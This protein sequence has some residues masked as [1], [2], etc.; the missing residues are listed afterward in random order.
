MLFKTAPLS[1]SFPSLGQTP[2]QK[3]ILLDECMP[4]VGFLLLDGADPDQRSAARSGADVFLFLID[5]IQETFGLAPI[6]GMAAGLPLLVSDWD[7]MKDT[8]T[9][10]VGFRVTS[11]ALS[12][13][14]LAQ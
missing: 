7:G 13:A 11:R 12:G 3:R 2:R 8:V 5:N 9:P 1:E 10:D 14:H 4:D 6:E